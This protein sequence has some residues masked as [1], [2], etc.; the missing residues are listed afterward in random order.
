M[1]V[2]LYLKASLG[3]ELRKTYPFSL[4]QFMYSTYFISVTYSFLEGRR[5]QQRPKRCSKDNQVFFY[6]TCLFNMWTIM[7][8]IN[9]LSL[10][11]FLQSF[12]LSDMCLFGKFTYC[13]LLS[14][15]A[16]KRTVGVKFSK[17]TC[18]II[19]TRKFKLPLSDFKDKRHF[20][21]FFFPF[22]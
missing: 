12:L 14:L 1:S 11:I 15:L 20:F 22:P 18:L 21:S 5:M 8:L 13:L 7:A 16:S 4:V 2:Q 6:V 3:K 17:P 19:R 10:K 9:F